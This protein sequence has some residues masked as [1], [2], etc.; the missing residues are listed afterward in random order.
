M[1]DAYQ[2]YNAVPDVIHCYCWSHMR[3]YWHRALPKNPK[4][5]KAKIGLAFCDKL[6]ELERQWKDLPQE[7]RYTRRDQHAKFILDAYFR[8]VECLNALE[9]S[10]LGNAVNYAMNNK[11]GLLGYL[12]DGRSGASYSSRHRNCGSQFRQHCYQAAL[13]DRRETP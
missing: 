10:G 8:W 12:K 2:G 4:G 1:S 7:Q 3:R 5:S 13:Q 6:F 11:T 9:G